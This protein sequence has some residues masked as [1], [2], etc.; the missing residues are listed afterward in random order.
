MIFITVG[1]TPYTF[2]RL[3]NQAI[4]YAQGHPR[5]PMIIQSGP[6][7]PMIPLPPNVTARSFY[8]YTDVVRYIKHSQSVVSH[9]GLGTILLALSLGKNPW[10]VPRRTLYHEHVNDHQVAL[11][12][13]LLKRGLVHTFQNGNAWNFSAYKKSLH[14]LAPPK[15]LLRS[16]HRLTTRLASS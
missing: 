2:S 6:Y 10:V 5:T 9:G 3:I 14:H 11:V 16:M 15:D 13:H 1:T 7:V 8:A 4:I 12:A